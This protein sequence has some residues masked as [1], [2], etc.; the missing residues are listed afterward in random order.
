MSVDLDKL[1]TAN[2]VPVE[3]IWTLSDVRTSVCPSEVT[4]AYLSSSKGK[5]VS[6]APAVTV[7][8]WLL[9]ILT[10]KTV[11]IPR[12]AFVKSTFEILTFGSL[13]YK[14]L[15]VDVSRFVVKIL[16]SVIFNDDDGSWP[17]ATP[18]TPVTPLTIIVV[19]PA[20]TTFATIGSLL[21][22]S[23]YWTRF[24]ILTTLPGNKVFGLVTVLTPPDNALMV[25]IPTLNPVDWIAS[26]EKVDADPTIPYTDFTSEIP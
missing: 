12:T 13:V 15:S 11:L 9:E 17:E 6:F 20:P 21:V 1:Y 3:S 16:K 8:V 19:L 14:V 18:L 23:L 25:A 2:W 4:N 7:V 10:V 5:K 26:A 22:G 24:P